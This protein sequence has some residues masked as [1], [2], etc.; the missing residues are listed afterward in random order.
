MLAMRQFASPCVNRST[1]ADLQN[2]DMVPWSELGGGES[3]YG[4]ALNG[5]D[6]RSEPEAC[7]RPYVNTLCEKGRCL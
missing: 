3:T 7:W 6:P 2:R 1:R 5:D 4:A